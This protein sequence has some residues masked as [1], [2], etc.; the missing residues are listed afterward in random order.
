CGQAGLR[1]R[2]HN[3][4]GGPPRTPNLPITNAPFRHPYA[5]HR[6]SPTNS[7]EEPEIEV[8]LPPLEEQQRIVTEIEGYQKVLD[9]ARQILAVYRPGF[10]IGPTWPVV[11]LDQITNQ[12][13]DGTHFTP[14]YTE[15]GVPFWR[16]TDL[17][18]SNDSKKFISNAEHVQLIK[19]CHPK[20]GD[21]LYSKNGTIGV[22]KKVDWDFEFSVFVSLAVLKP[23]PELTDSSFLEY[24]MNSPFVYSQA[25]SRSKSNTVTNLHLVEIREFEI[26]LPP[27]EEQRRIVAE[28]DAEAAQIDAVRA[29]IPCFEAKI[30]RVIDRVWGNNGSE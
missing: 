20:K 30:Q 14:T 19:R 28:L 8:L 24:T 4:P 29:L 27:L 21:I 16:V 2:G 3:E 13:T 15:S 17:T 6:N 25:V 5:I 9:G 12:I 1:L 10:A 23:K 18:Q 11:T 22:A 26:P 7:G